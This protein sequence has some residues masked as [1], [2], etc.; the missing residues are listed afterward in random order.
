MRFL[1]AILFFFAI[2]FGE[3]NGADRELVK[4]DERGN[5]YVLTFDEFGRV[6]SVK[7]QNP[8][9]MITASRQMKYDVAGNKIAKTP[10]LRKGK[11]HCVPSLPTARLRMPSERADRP[12]WAGP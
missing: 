4:S 10:H 1:L 3:A 12:L 9:G 7:E 5:H 6:E 11:I 2:F 8:Q